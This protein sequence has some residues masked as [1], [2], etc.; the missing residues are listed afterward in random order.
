MLRMK[1]RAALGRAASWNR[2]C[3]LL[4]IGEDDPGDDC[5]DGEGDGYP[6]EADGADGPA[7]LQGVP[8]DQHVGQVRCQSDVERCRYFGAVLADGQPC[9]SQ[10]GEEVDQ[11]G[12]NKDDG[13]AAPWSWELP[14]EVSAA[15]RIRPTIIRRAMVAM[16]SMGSS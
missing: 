13:A 1:K 7:D 9:L 3:L 11:R 4:G 8:D 16:T 12:Y 2:V 15:G 14:A 5:Q 6:G 10:G